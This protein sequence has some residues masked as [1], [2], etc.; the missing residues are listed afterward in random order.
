L[1]QLRIGAADLISTRPLLRGLTDDPDLR[2]RLTFESPATLGDS[3]DQ[4]RYDVALV[5]SIEYLRGVGSNLVAGPALV[6]RTSPGGIVLVAR[7]PLDALERI[8]VG[9]FCRTPVAALRIVLA[10]QYQVFPDLL[11]EKRILEDDWRDRYDA[12]LLTGDAA[13]AEV[14]AAATRGVMRYNVTEMWRNVTRKPL[15]HAVWAYD[16]PALC[17]EVTLLLTASRDEG[18][19]HLSEISDDVAEVTCFDR[20]A[21]YDHLSRTWAYELGE[22]E[23]DGL[24]VLNDLAR[25]YDLIRENRLAVGASA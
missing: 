16:R 6:G 2:S 7:K 22:S 15:V 18:I 20:M 17:D 1:S 21:V 4:G 5:P 23:R 11:V 8:A 3:L 13:L 24:R 19:G 9:E 12:A 25:K 14:N 10:E